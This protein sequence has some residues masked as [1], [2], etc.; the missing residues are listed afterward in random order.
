MP[1]RLAT[2]DMEDLPGDEGGLLQVENPV[3]DVADLAR[4]TERVDG[5]EAVV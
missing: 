2:V 1:S 3:D 4:A 5:S